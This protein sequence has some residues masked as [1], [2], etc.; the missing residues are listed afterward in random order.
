[1]IC[2][3]GYAV[4]QDTAG[5]SSQEQ[6]STKLLSRE[7]IK[8]GFDYI[9]A[10]AQAQTVTYTMVWLVLKNSKYKKHTK[11]VVISNMLIKNIENV[12]KELVF[13]YVH[14]NFQ[15]AYKR[16]VFLFLLFLKGGAMLRPAVWNIAPPL[17]KPKNKQKQFFCMLFEKMNENNKKKFLYSMFNV[18]Y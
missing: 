11:E 9:R 14:S 17:Q 1:M 16:I 3:N 8:D 10:E 6:D 5:A 13:C 7:E 18:F 4:W 15:K 2:Y 12:I